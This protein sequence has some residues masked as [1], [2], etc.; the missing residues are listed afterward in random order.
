MRLTRELIDVSDEIRAVGPPPLPLLPDPFAVRVA[1][2]ADA[3]LVADWMGRP[4]LAK[5]WE[6]D[7]PVARWRQHLRVQLDGTYSLPV[8]GSIS[9]TPH[10]Y[11]E[12]YR[13]A[14]DSIAE[15]YE[16]DPHDIGLHVAIG[17]PDDVH[18]G[19]A[20]QVFPFLIGGVFDGDV[21]CCRILF[22]PDHRNV[23]ARQACEYFGCQYLGEHDM[24]NRRMALYAYERPSS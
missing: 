5:T 17:E 11:F 8:V 13:A 23:A 18:Q 24:P 12:L 20:A 10:T 4:H 14:K 3:E 16:A 6:Y 2:V 1:T 7:W 22:D 21:A 9:G 19:L 15:Y